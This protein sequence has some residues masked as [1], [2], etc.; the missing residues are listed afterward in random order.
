MVR[1]VFDG[2]KEL[3]RTLGV[4]GHDQKF[5]SGGGHIFGKER[6]GGKASEVERTMES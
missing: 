5:D 6:K 3:A 1:R 2:L 4:Q